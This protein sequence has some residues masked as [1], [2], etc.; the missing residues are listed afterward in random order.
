[1]I[2]H[3]AM[4]IVAEHGLASCIKFMAQIEREQIT[5]LR[6]WWWSSDKGLIR[7]PNDSKEIIVKAQTMY[8]ALRGEGVVIDGVKLMGNVSD[9]YM[10]TLRNSHMQD[11]LTI[12]KAQHP[13]P[14]EVPAPEVVLFPEQPVAK[15]VWILAGMLLLGFIYVLGFA[16]L[17]ILS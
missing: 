2:P 15:W 11:I 7:D 9:A 10:E 1:M 3:N 8:D 4:V 14:P 16:L 13:V 5:D 12:N 17:N 6:D